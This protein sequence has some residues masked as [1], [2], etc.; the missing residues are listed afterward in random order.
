MIALWLVLACAEERAGDPVVE[1][2]RGAAALWPENSRTAMLA[3]IAAG[4]EGLE[5]D[6][7]LT[8]DLVPVLSHDPTVSHHTCTTLDGEHLD[9]GL[10]IQDYTLAELQGQFLCGA[11]PDPLFPDVALVPES[12]MTWSELLVALS[13]PAAEGMEIHIDV[14]FE[15]G[16]TPP[17]ADFAAAI[18]D[19][20]W[21]TDLDN[22][23]FVSA[24]LVEALDAFRAH[25]DAAGEPLRTSLI[26][27][28]FTPDTSNTVVGLKH[29]LRKTFGL[30]S[31]TGV[32]RSAGVD[33]LAVP[34]ALVDRGGAVEAWDA[35][36]DVRV[37]TLNTPELLETYCDWPLKGVITDIPDQAPCG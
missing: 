5:F 18:L 2:H 20:W 1:A 12:H 23:M 9:E 19:P 26:W 29:E 32:A 10:L 27:P 15:P 31:L 6:V 3:S 13:D 4:F 14:K 30:D 11:L 16:Q 7:V 17:A 35:G 37:W 8:A 22:P 36:L 21:L 24:N 28:R 33:G 34:Y 25:A